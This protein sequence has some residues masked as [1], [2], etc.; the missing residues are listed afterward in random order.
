M[1]VR[2]EDVSLQNFHV[3]KQSSSRDQGSTF[4]VHLDLADDAPKAKVR[5]LLVSVAVKL[6]EDPPESEGTWMQVIGHPPRRYGQAAGS[7][8]AFRSM[9]KHQSL[10]TPTSAG[11][12][13]KIVLFYIK[14]AI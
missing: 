1:C 11:E 12:I 8:L 5:D 2:G 13:L 14:R 7:V 6:T 9:T 3:L 10:L 4:G